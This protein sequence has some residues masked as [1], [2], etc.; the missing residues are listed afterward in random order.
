VKNTPSASAAQRNEYAFEDKTKMEERERPRKGRA[1]KIPL[2]GK[3][4]VFFNV[5]AG[6]EAA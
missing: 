3:N 4:C 1:V 2:L 6:V 5:L